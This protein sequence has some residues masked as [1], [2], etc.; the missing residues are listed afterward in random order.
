MLT[1][2]NI[3]AAFAA[4]RSEMKADFIAYLTASLDRLVRRFGPT[5][6]ELSRAGS[7]FSN[8]GAYAQIRG[9]LASSPS[10]S[11]TSSMSEIARFDEARLDRAA[12]RFVEATVDALVAKVTDRVSDLTDAELVG[13]SG[14]RFVL[15][16]KRGADSVR[17]VQDQILNVSKLGKLFNQW[18]CRI[19]LN[20][21]RIS[22]KDYAAL[23]AIEP[24]AE[25]RENSV[26][27]VE[28][29]GSV[30]VFAV[31][32]AGF[33]FVV[34]VETGAKVKVTVEAAEGSEPTRAAKMGARRAARKMATGSAR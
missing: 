24:V 7:C 15:V 8:H 2:E 29:N 1:N 27:L 16:G 3:T 34:T 6:G 25:T 5:K 4:H 14:A 13:V 11:Y 33:D 10:R 31:V 26:E 23:P 28:E 32:R 12:E 19:Y 17:F 21:S 9:L 20:G 22:A 18:P 30:K